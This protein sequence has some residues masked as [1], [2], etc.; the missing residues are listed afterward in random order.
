MRN[1]IACI[2]FAALSLN[3]GFAAAQQIAFTSRAYVDSP[4]LL[5]SLESSADYG[6]ESVVLRND[7]PDKATALQLQIVVRSGSPSVPG[8]DEIADRRRVVVDLD[9]HE[10]KRVTIGMGQIQG[11]RDQVR[12]RKQDS[13][14]VII[15]IEAVE[16]RDG[17][18]WKRS[19][20]PNRDVPAQPAEIPKKK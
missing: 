12:A 20:S 6:F 9:R 14:L 2:A 15:T 13:A 11:L 10:T 8:E 16:F 18:E 7:G 19:D 17:S 5:S 3:C 1:R 4:V